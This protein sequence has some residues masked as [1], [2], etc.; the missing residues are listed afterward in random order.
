[1]EDI[2]VGIIKFIGGIV[3]SIPFNP[4]KWKHW[5]FLLMLLLFVFF[6]VFLITKN[7]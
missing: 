2:F 7:Y 5:A 4:K 6:L 3:D 1:M